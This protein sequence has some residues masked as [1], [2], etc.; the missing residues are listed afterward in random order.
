MKI[1]VTTNTKDLQIYGEYFDVCIN[2]KHKFLSRKILGYDVIIYSDAIFSTR[3]FVIC[4]AQSQKIANQIR[5]E[6]VGQIDIKK[7]EIQID[8]RETLKS[9]N[10]I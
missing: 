6:I 5:Q 7:E 2:I 1:S 4:R 10:I 3:E 8:L 9:L